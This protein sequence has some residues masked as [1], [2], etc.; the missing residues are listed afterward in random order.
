MN[1]LLDTHI[2]LWYISGDARLALHHRDSIRDPS[3]RVYL[4]VASVWEAVIK[5]AIGKLA[6]PQSPAAY[7]PQQR[8]GHRIDS[9]PI[10]ESPLAE[11]ASLPPLHRDPFDRLL[12]AQALFYGMTLVTVDPL[13]QAYPVPVL[14]I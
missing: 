3:N 4:S 10:E 11:L 14:P 12:V 9:L 5:H 8:R 13:I 7:L 2:F 6:L 1:L